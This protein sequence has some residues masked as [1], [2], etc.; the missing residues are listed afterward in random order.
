MSNNKNLYNLLLEKYKD[1]EKMKWFVGDVTDMSNFKSEL[2]HIIIDKGLLD[3][4]ATHTDSYNNIKTAYDQCN[5]LL[6]RKG[7]IIL[8]TYS[9]NRT[10]NLDLNKF[11]IIGQKNIR[12][13]EEPLYLNIIVKK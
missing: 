10:D 4:L 12:L 2:F 8:I 7:M 9:K 5:Y 6:K 3:T 1:K 11:K 13:K